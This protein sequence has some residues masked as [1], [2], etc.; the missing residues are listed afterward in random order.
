MINYSDSMQTKKVKDSMVDRKSQWYAPPSLTGQEAVL[1]FS[2]C[3]MGYLEYAISLILSVDMFSP[4]QTFILHLINPDQTGFDQFDKFT[5]QLQNTTVYLSYETTDLS[6]LTEDQQKAYYASARFLQLKN[7]LADYAT[8]VFSIDADSLVMNP[9]DLDFS[10]KTD[11]E[12]ILVRRDAVPGRA[13]HLAVATG[14][15]WMAPVEHVIK[16]LETVASDIDQAFEEGSLAW[17]VDQKVFYLR[18]KEALK[19]VHFYNIKQKYADWHF[20]DSGILWA[21]KGGLKLYDLR[22]FILQNLLSIHD[23]KRLMAQN[24]VG[25]YFLPQSSLFS[26]WMQLRIESAVEK[27]LSMKSKPLPRNGRVAFYIPRLDLPWKRITNNPNTAPEVSEDV[28]D[29]RLQWKRFALLAANALERKGL[30]VDVYE[31]P[32]WEIDRTRIDLDNA[33]LAFVPHRCDKNFG[34]GYVPVLFYMQ[35]FF[36]WT[37]VV[38]NKGWSAASSEYPVQLDLEAQQSGGAFEHYRTRLL[39]GQL[40]SKFAQRDTSPLGELLKN[41]LLPAEKNWLGRHV[42]RPYIFFPVQIPTDQSIQFFSDSSVL[43]VVTALINWAREAGVVVVL[44][45]H[46]A[47]RKSMIPFENLADGKTVFVSDANIK[48]LIEHSTAVYTVNSGVG[49][50]ALLQLKPVVTFGRVEYDC[51][52][53]NATTDTLSD[54][55]AYAGNITTAELEFKYRAFMNWFLKDYSVDMSTPANAKNRLDAIAAVVADIIATHEPTQG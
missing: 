22:F 47:N 40:A 34:P 7:L 39:T 17:F 1:L 28:I 10:D 15:I 9:I 51:V 13:E 44:K 23:A 6:G 12:I 5:T 53:F 45:L 50:E 21:G 49:F 38:D 30:S 41:G 4:G 33:S 2:A 54:A 27:S 20:H 43:D 3:D 46:P 35:E 55:W 29:L 19:T 48:D 32:N 36:R 25:T 8:P 42:L 16:F 26:E 52:T 31:I 14:S 11:A 37:F 18:M 24:L